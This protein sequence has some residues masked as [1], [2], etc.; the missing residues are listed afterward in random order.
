MNWAVE[1]QTLMPRVL[2][3]WLLDTVERAPEASVNVML[4]LYQSHRDVDLKYSGWQ[5][6]FSSA[7][8]EVRRYAQDI[9]NQTHATGRETE[10]REL[11]ATRRALSAARRT[12]TSTRYRG[13]EPGEP[14]VMATYCRGCRDHDDV[15]HDQLPTYLVSSGAYIAREKARCRRCPL[16]EIDRNRGHIHARTQWI[17]LE[18]WYPWVNYKSVSGFDN[19]RFDNY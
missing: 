9:V 3:D 12:V 11:T 10:Y 4:P 13:P 5:F 14:Q 6:A 15:W 1:L 7:D 16:T 17:P 19:S 18:N 2:D 8:P